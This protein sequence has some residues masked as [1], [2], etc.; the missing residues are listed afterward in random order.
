MAWGTNCSEWDDEIDWAN[1]EANPGEEIPESKF[2]MT[3]RHDDELLGEVLWFS[4]YCARHP[5][6]ELR[7]TLILHVSAADRSDELINM[8]REAK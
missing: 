8:L 5:S 1:I 4:A 3:T 7:Q 6:V 2:I